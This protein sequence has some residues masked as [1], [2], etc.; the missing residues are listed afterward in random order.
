MFLISV[1]LIPVSL[2]MLINNVLTLLYSLKP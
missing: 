2:E 1:I